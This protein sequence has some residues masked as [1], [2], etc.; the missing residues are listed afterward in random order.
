MGKLSLREA[1]KLFDVSRPTLTKA[2]KEHRIS[3]EKD[4]D[5]NWHIEPSEL[6]RL[7]RLRDGAGGKLL[8]AKLTKP[9][10]GQ[11]STV[12]QDA[13]AAR[14]AH[15]EGQLEA[16]RE[17]RELVERHLADLR[18]LLPAPSRPDAPPPRRRRWWPFG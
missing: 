3:A 15:L 12:S 8:P 4:S 13:A 9:Y 7:Y 11:V 6:S 10:E 5:G 1:V 14:I 17:K 2:L 16:E 18:A